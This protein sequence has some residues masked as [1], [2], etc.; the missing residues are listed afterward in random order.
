MSRL[1]TRMLF[2]F[3]EDGE[4]PWFEAFLAFVGDVDNA[5]FADA[6]NNNL[7]ATGSALFTWDA[8]AGV[9]SWDADFFFSGFTTPFF[10]RI[11]GPTGSPPTLLN[12]GAGNVEQGRHSY[13]V[14]F[15]DGSN[16][17]TTAGPAAAIL[18]NSNSQVAVSGI[19]IG[20]VGTVK[21][22]IYRTLANGSA[23][24]LLTTI[25]NNTGTTFTDNVADASLGA[26]PPNT[27]QISQITVLE[28]QVIYFTMP[29]GLIANTDVVLGAGNVVANSQGIRLHDQIVVCTRR[30]DV[31]YF[32]NGVALSDGG[33]GPVW[34]RPAPPGSAGLTAAQRT[35]INAALHT[36]QDFL[37]ESVG[38]STL[39]FTNP[40]PETVQGVEVY[41]N[42]ILIN[43][44]TGF[45]TRDYTTNFG[46][47]PC[48]IN[49]VLA[50]TAPDKYRV[51]VQ[52]SKT[53]AP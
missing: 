35:V 25:N 43:E 32:R 6:D 18:L 48:Q 50:P 51:R 11:K 12:A 15:M 37:Y 41:R 8:T 1:S 39:T 14:V 2:V 53:V 38:S 3:P 34:E 9:L 33:S 46:A 4:D 23:Y 36:H 52:V 17:E 42:G 49:L 16:V 24:K 19:S 5:S 31:I 28:G 30:N 26:A 44:T 20:P 47:S 13:L 45:T 40:S 7:I 21:R 10:A 29:R 22:R 27:V